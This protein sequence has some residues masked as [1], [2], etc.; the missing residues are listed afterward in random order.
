MLGYSPMIDP[1]AKRAAPPLWLLV[2]ITISGTMAMHMFV[3]ALPDAAQALGTGTGPMQMAISLYVSGLAIGQLFYGPLSDALGRRPLLL[4]G[5]A[6]YTLASLVAGL[7]PGLGTLLAARLLQALG[8]CAGL[9]LGRAMVRDTSSSDTAVRQLALLNL[10]IM[11][12]PGFAP[13]VGG[14]L[15]G[16]FGWRSVFFLLA[17]VGALTLVFAW[18]LLPETGRPGGRVGAR[19]LAA[20]Y[21]SLLSS[22][23]FV[24]LLIGGSCATT[25]IY[26][27]LAAAPFIFTLELHKSIHEVGFYSGLI[28]LGLALGNLFTGRLSRRISAEVLLR[29]GTILSLASAITLLVVVLF[30]RLDLVSTLG[31]MLVFTCGAGMASPAALAQAISVDP[32]RIGSAAGLYGFGQ[33][34]VGALCTTLSA[35][36]SDPALSAASVL[37]GATV[38]SQVALTFGLRRS[39]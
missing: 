27:F 28:V 14:A 39:G 17:A 12:G 25:S 5:L 38:L 30:H 1:S 21:A 13:M 3:P 20:D 15:A 9:A 4:F 34:A 37:V 16:S 26:A 8:G 18:R 7:A 24:A 10:M 33:M 31:I 19:V 23:R 35:T 36:G 11:I 22:R 29:V 6:L 32:N 2:L